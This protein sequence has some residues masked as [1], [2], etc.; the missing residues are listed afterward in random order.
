MSL[1]ERESIGISITAAFVDHSRSEIPEP[2]YFDSIHFTFSVTNL[3]NNAVVGL[4][5]YNRDVHSKVFIDRKLFG[6]L[7]PYGDGP[8][9]GK[10]MLSKGESD[11]IDWWHSLHPRYPYR[12]KTFTIQWEYLGVKSEILKVDVPNRTIEVIKK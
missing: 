2:E 1:P 4:A 6:P 9:Q 12:D 10:E 5:S 3:G 8:A 11:S 7:V